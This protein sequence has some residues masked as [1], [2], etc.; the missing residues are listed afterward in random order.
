MSRR[1]DFPSIILGILLLFGMHVAAVIIGSMVAIIANSLKLNN[2]AG[3]F[4]YGF[5]GLGL[6]QVLYV[7][8]VVIWL[9]RRQSWG[10]MKG[11]IIGAVMTALLNGGC[12]LL[13]FSMYHR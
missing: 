10:L 12:W 8:P 2:I 11:V 13:I 1:D 9:K 4:I 6:A 7:I 3:L 5:V